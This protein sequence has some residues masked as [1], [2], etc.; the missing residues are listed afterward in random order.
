MYPKYQQWPGKKLEIRL[1]FW[2]VCTVN[3]TVAVQ[4]REIKYAFLQASKTAPYKHCIVNSHNS[5]T[6]VHKHSLDINVCYA[7][8]AE[9]IFQLN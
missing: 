9:I 5:L 2:N 6:L 1:L 7:L 3:C 4:M 8:I